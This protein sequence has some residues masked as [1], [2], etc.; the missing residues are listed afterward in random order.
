MVKGM[1]SFKNATTFS[2][3]LTFFL[4]DMGLWKS[5]EKRDTLTLIFTN[6]I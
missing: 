6:K 3:R 2:K 4:R 5:D 1:D